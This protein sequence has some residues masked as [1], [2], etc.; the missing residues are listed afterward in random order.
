MAASKFLADISRITKKVYQ[1]R[2]RS[3]LML[4][5]EKITTKR[6]ILSVR[7]KNKAGKIFG[8]GMLR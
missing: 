4:I 8:Q 2:E 3:K 1:A 7:R 5:T 6:K